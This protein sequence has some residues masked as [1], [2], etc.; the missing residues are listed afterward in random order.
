MISFVLGLLFLTNPTASAEE[1]ADA[2]FVESSMTLKVENKDQVAEELI[3]KAEEMGGY[4]QRRDD[5]FLSLKVPTAKTTAFIEFAESRGLVATR[6][7]ASKSLSQ[8]LANTRAKLKAREELLEKYFAI[9]DEAKSSAVIT[10]EREVIRLVTE[11]ENLKGVERKLSHQSLFS[12]IS[13]GFQFR[14]RRAPSSDGTSSFGWI[15]SL[16]VTALIDEFRYGSRYHK[17]KKVKVSPP[18]GFAPYKFK[19]EFRAISHDNVIYRV[20]KI[21]PKQRAD[22]HF[23]GEAVAKRMTDAGYL[24]YSDD[25]KLEAKEIAN[26]GRLLKMIAPFGNDDYAYWVAFQFSGN[27][28]IIVEATGEA[29]KFNASYADSITKQLTSD[30]SQ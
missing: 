28:L 29:G 11:I 21:K 10:V 9:L 1:P 2:L 13:I 16:N 27:M 12:N 15:N 24:T 7:F 14:D 20:R 5:S 23:W 3:K 25:K 6:D 8:D 22:I 4:Y 30:F 18:E 17:S 19:R 26:N